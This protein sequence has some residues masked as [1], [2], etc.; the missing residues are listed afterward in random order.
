MSD[1]QS[2]D[3]YDL[4]TNGEVT[5]EEAVLCLIGN[6]CEIALSLK[7]SVDKKYWFHLESMKKGKWE[8]IDCNR[9]L[10]TPDEAA[11]INQACA[12]DM[13]WISTLYN[14]PSNS[15]HHADYKS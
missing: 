1:K 3:V 10:I 14:C 4:W 15:P 6:A 13:R 11:W 8:H 12:S 5:G 9:I 2:P 7:Q